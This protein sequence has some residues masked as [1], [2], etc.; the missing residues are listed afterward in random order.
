MTKSNIFLGI[1][2]N[3]GI[4]YP[5]FFSGVDIKAKSCPMSGQYR[6]TPSTTNKQTLQPVHPANQATIILPS[7]NT[8]V[9]SAVTDR[10][11]AADDKREV[12]ATLLTK[13]D[14]EPDP[15]SGTSSGSDGDKCPSVVSS[16]GNPYSLRFFNQCTNYGK[17]IIHT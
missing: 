2:W 5:F 9:A 4:E 11:T 13:E 14:G 8:P 3:N 17:G 6:I 12:S 15:L 7:I 1:L 10:K 16:C